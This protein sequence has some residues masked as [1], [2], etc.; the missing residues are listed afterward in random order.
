MKISKQLPKYAVL[1]VVIAGLGLAFSGFFD[2]DKQGVR[3][4]VRVPELSAAALE[5]RQ[6]YDANCAQCHGKNA[7][8]TGKGPPLIHNFYKPGHHGDQAFITAVKRGVRQHHWPYGNMKP[9]PKVT[10]AELTVIVKYVRE[11]Q[12]ANGIN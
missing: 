1:G 9:L 10:D 12:A 3:V 11:V 2:K 7:S 6:A 8:G 4:D 5:G